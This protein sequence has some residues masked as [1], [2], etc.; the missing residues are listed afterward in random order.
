[1]TVR[2]PLARTGAMWDEFKPGDVMAKP[3]AP[4]AAV[5]TAGNLTV[6]TAQILS[7]VC[8]FTGAAAAVAYTYPT[9]TV[10]DAALPDMRIGDTIEFTVINTAAQ[11]ATMTTAAG[12]TLSGNVTI[13]AS[14]RRVFMTKTAAATYT[15]V[16]A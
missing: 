13:N 10:L 11:V 12:L 16:H 4:S 5:A 9:G 2:V 14:S 7:G 6:T 15:L 1:M 3:G 8:H